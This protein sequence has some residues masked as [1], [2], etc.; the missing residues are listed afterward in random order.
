MIGG[1][2]ALALFGLGEEL[3]A[4]S[5]SGSSSSKQRIGRYRRVG[6]EEEEDQGMSGMGGMGI[7]SIR[8]WKGALWNISDEGRG[9]GLI[10]KVMEVYNWG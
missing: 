5:C 4:G 9:W 7:T 8:G 1:A 10:G 2:Q 6:R 3:G